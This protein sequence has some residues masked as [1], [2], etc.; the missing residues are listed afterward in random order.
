MN[1]YGRMPKIGFEVLL[2]GSVFMAIV[3]SPGY[4]QNAAAIPDFSGLWGR[5][6]LNLE[7]PPSGPG[8]VVNMMHTPDGTQDMNKLVGDYN[9]PILKPQAA[10]I[11]KQRG[12][13]SLDG[14][15]VSNPHEECR[16]EPPP[17]LFAVQF[18]FE[19]LQ[20]KDEIALLYSHD[21]KV[22]HVRMNAAHPANV[23]PTGQGDSVGHYEGDTLVIDTI[24]IKSSPISAVDWYG[25]PHSDALHVVERYRLID[26]AAAKAAAAKH[27]AQYRTRPRPNPN[28]VVLDKTYVGKGLQLELTVEDSGMFTMPWKALVTYQR[29]EGELWEMRCAENFRAYYDNADAPIPQADRPDF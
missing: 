7:S 16:P 23:K 27:D 19:M 13:M 6:S 22:R 20:Q 10:A 14:K 8:P 26:Q 17:L 4:A 5:D 9:N 1:V 29:A 28:G 24:G 15:S 18:A 12:Q 21:N 3:A 11:L 25:T 2:G